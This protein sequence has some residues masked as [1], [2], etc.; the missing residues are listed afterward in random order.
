MIYSDFSKL[1]MHRPLELPSCGSS[2]GI[3]ELPTAV[4]VSST[5]NSTAV[6]QLD[7]FHKETLEEANHSLSLSDMNHVMHAFR[8]KR[9][10]HGAMSLLPSNGAELLFACFTLGND[11]TSQGTCMAKT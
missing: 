3:V 2:Q 4:M 5:C 6:P 1:F 8:A 10:V 11:A 9:S 7:I